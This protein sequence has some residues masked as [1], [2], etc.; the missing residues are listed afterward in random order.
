[1]KK[2]N[3]SK[4][5][6]RAWDIFRK[7]AK[8]VAIS[9][10]EALRRSWAAEKAKPENEKRIAEAKAAAGISAE[11]ETDTYSG[12]QS[13]GFEVIHESKALFSAVLIWASKGEGKTY[14]VSFFSA[15]QVQPIEAAAA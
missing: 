9:F 12:W 1:M 11:I 14:K 7:A 2:Y 8:K 15:D 5:M 13:K 10:A 6:S 3:L 4:I